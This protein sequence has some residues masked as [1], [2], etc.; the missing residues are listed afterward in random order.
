MTSPPSTSANSP[1]AGSLLECLTGE[2]GIESLQPKRPTLCR[3]IGLPPRADL[4]KQA[5]ETR[6]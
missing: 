3:A 1:N 6:A 5:G 4:R 2:G